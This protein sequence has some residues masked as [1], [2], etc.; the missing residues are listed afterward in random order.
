MLNSGLDKVRWKRIRNHY[1]LPL[2][3]KS[4]HWLQE[5][6]LPPLPTVCLYK[7][8][9]KQENKKNMKKALKPFFSSQFSRRKKNIIPCV[10][11]LNSYLCETMIYSNNQLHSFPPYK[12]TGKSKGKTYNVGVE[13][14]PHPGTTT[15]A[16]A[17]LLQ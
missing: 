14:G 17:Y 15:R 9:V 5:K 11:N 8:T 16:R 10:T 2:M 3:A 4:T 7:F 6:C 12:L 13:I 1:V